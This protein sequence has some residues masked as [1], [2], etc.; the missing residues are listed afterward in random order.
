MDKHRRIA[1]WMVVGALLGG[2]VVSSDVNALVFNMTDG[3]AFEIVDLGSSDDSFFNSLYYSHNYDQ[4]NLLLHEY[5]VGAS[6]MNWYIYDR[7]T[8]DFTTQRY[9][10]SIVST[11][12]S[13]WVDYNTTHLLMISCTGGTDCERYWIRRDNITKYEGDVFDGYATYGGSPIVASNG[14]FFLHPSVSTGGGL[15]FTYVN[16]FNQTGSLYLPSSITDVVEADVVY[17]P[18]VHEYWLFFVTASGSTYTYKL[19]LA[20]YS[21]SNYGYRGLWQVTTNTVRK[22]QP[23]CPNVDCV[24]FFSSRYYDNYVYLATFE[25]STGAEG[26]NDYVYMRIYDPNDPDS[27]IEVTEEKINLTAYDPSLNTSSCNAQGLSFAYD[28][29]YGKYWFTYGKKTGACGVSSEVWGLSSYSSCVCTEWIDNG[30]CGAFIDNKQYEYRNCNPANCQDEF[31][32]TDCSEADVEILKE[33]YTDARFGCSEWAYWEDGKTVEITTGIEIPSFCDNETIYIWTENIPETQG[34]SDCD[35]GFYNL[36][37]CLP[38]FDC[39]EH[40]ARC[41]QWNQ[42]Y[43][44]SWGSSINYTH[45]LISPHRNITAK[46]SLFMPSSCRCHNVLWWDTGAEYYRVCQKINLRCEKYCED[47]CYCGDTKT[48]RCE[49]NCIPKNYTDCIGEDVCYEYNY[50]NADCL[51]PDEISQ[52]SP[53]TS[54]FCPEGD[55]FTCIKAQAE[56]TFPTY[57]TMGLGLLISVGGG[58]FATIQTK[59]WQMGAIASMGFVALFLALGGKWM[60]PVLAILW[61]LG[62]GV[63][64]MK[65][66]FFKEK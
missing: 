30:G 36:T 24:G 18:T 40:T 26:D 51:N 29:K 3:K 38:R 45:E 13:D 54:Q 56:N 21:A 41:D 16:T 66:I 57:V 53:E 47:R 27:L 2:I 9:S 58:V 63:I 55:I 46:A 32:Y 7:N 28:R 11:P 35:K 34:G 25:N 60:N 31:R 43:W 4:F 6:K 15:P 17:V 48:V 12:I 8:T 62:I 59:N 20:R 33:N 37:E 61:I 65:G 42:S 50:Y 1:F 23:V 22:W 52:V 5:D 64:L 49:E 10:D 14:V 44:G 39:A 19:Y